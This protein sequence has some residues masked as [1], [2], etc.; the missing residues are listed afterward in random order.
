MVVTENI[1]SQFPKELCISGAHT[2]KT[3]GTNI[4]ASSTIFIFL[5]RRKVKFE[6]FFNPYLP[7]PGGYVYDLKDFSTSGCFDEWDFRFRC[8]SPNKQTFDPQ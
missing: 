4:S 8:V 3:C 1:E 6:D 2:K 5:V 7:F